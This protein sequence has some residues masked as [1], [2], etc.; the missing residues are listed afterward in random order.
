[1]GHFGLH[2][3]TPSWSRTLVQKYF[4]QREEYQRTGVR[5]R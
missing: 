1:M 2:I 5:N 4:L 3:N